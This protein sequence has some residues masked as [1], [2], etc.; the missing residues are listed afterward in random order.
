MMTG[1][2]QLPKLR[3]YNQ[4]ELEYEKHPSLE[5]INE[6]IIKISVQ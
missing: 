5:F 1:Y 3:C 2:I 6:E 4:F